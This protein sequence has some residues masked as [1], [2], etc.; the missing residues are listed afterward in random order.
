M[1]DVRAEGAQVEHRFEGVEGHGGQAEGVAGARQPAQ[2][3]GQQ[4]IEQTGGQQAEGH[5]EQRHQRLRQGGSGKA[6]RED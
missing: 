6:Q 5:G 4:E 3:A 2:P 1:E